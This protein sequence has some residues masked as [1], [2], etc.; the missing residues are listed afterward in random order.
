MRVSSFESATSAF[1]YPLSYSLSTFSASPR[2]SSTASSVSLMALA[3]APIGVTVPLSH[4]KSTSAG[5]VE[6]H[7]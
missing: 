5:A 6:R 7:S 3:I 4:P 2:N 1:M